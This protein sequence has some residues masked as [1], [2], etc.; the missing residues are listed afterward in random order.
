[1]RDR[2]CGEGL[3]RLLDFDFAAIGFGAAVFFGLGF[4][5]GPAVFFGFGFGAAVFFGAGF[6]LSFAAAVFFAFAFAFARG[7]AACDVRFL[8]R[9]FAVFAGF[10]VF[11]TISTV[12]ARLR[13]A[14]FLRDFSRN[15][16]PDRR[17]LLARFRRGS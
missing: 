14:G 13:F 9:T 5:F 11:F 15:F 7:F 8:P 12:F 6:D 1:M 2:C 3:G 16:A 10:R 17:F 4:G